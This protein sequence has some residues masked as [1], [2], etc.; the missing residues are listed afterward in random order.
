MQ[1]AVRSCTAACT[2]L[3]SRPLFPRG[4]IN[5]LPNAGV[6]ATSK[7]LIY[8]QN[9]QRGAGRRH[10]TNRCTWLPAQRSCR[11]QLPVSCQIPKN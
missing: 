4:A 3:L 1:A 11:L 2:V 8:G 6:F 5:M 9:N 10:S 7:A